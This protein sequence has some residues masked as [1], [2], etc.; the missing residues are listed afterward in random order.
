[1]IDWA[2]DGLQSVLCEPLAI[3]K[4]AWPALLTRLAYASADERPESDGAAQV[5]LEERVRIAGPTRLPKS[6]GA[7]AILPI[8]GT[9][10]QHNEW[11]AGVSTE[12]IGRVVEGL[13]GRQEVGAIILDIDS[14]GGV[15]SGTP[16]LSDKLFGLRGNGKPIY[17]I[18]NSMAASAAYWIGS[19][20]DKLFVT[21]SGEVGSIGVWSAHVDVSGMEASL[22]IKTTLIS[23]GKYKVEGNPWE[24]LG[25][26]ARESIQANVDHYY[27]EFVAA[28]ARNRGV[29]KKVAGGS[30]FGEGRMVTASAARAAGMVDGV[31]TLDEL[32]AGIAKP[33]KGSRANTLAA[34]I[35]MAEAG[36]D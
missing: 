3:D 18:A 17:A 34:E 22:G 14:P 30:D 32:I 33:A 2:N 8:R 25:D 1:M 36:I 5:D 10:A 24:P 15:V 28:V 16:E 35:A 9:I 26:E 6:S 11:W 21:P 13:L 20:A 29:S 12:A 19:A 31:L 4:R 23:A 27:G 7:V